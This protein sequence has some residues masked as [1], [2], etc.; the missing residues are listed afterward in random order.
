LA[1]FTAYS[2]KQVCEGCKFWDFGVNSFKRGKILHG[3]FT[4]GMAR[5]SSEKVLENR[6]F[7]IIS[8]KFKE[9]S[10]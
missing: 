2:L 8:A 4:A 1:S 3:K 7:A 5:V 10:R 9:L 6:P